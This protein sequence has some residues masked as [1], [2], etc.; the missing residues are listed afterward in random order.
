MHSLDGARTK[1][2]RAEEQVRDL[3]TTLSD[4]AGR[5]P[6][7][8]IAHTDPESGMLTLVAGKAYHLEAKRGS[9][10]IMVYG[11]KFVETT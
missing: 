5:E 11:A 10:W 3:Q 4:Y 6:H 8:V 9:T 7:V 1:I 2:K